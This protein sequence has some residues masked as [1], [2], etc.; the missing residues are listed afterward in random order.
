MIANA[1]FCAA[2]SSETSCSSSFKAVPEADTLV[3]GGG[4]VDDEMFPVV[5]FCQRFEICLSGKRPV[6]YIC[7]GITG[8]VTRIIAI[9]KTITNLGL[10]RLLVV[11][12]GNVEVVLVKDAIRSDEQGLENLYLFAKVN[13]E[14]LSSQCGIHE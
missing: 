3:T 12:E 6:P 14:K 2:L 1:S 5:I 13:V 11:T 8:N 10:E 9:M 4:E 7:I